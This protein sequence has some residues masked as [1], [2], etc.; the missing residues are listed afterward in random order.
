MPYRRA[1]ASSW[2]GISFY[3]VTLNGDRRAISDDVHAYLAM[4]SHPGGKVYESGERQYRTLP[5]D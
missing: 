2:G 3:P 1:A 4:I 5:T